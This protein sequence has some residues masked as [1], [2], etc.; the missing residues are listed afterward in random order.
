MKKQPQALV[1]ILPEQ[2]NDVVLFMAK[3]VLNIFNSQ[4]KE[5]QHDNNSRSKNS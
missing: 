3:M 2:R 4:I 1:N 5:V